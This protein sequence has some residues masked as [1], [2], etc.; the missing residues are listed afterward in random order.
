VI[1]VLTPEQ[2]R[3]VDAAAV[4]AVGEDALMHEAGRQ[5]ARALGE[6]NT[7]VRRVVAFAGPGNNGGDAF[8]ALAEL[9]RE[10]ER[11]V[12]AAPS[13]KPSAARTAAMS[14]AQES[15][16]VTRP[17]PQTED[18]AHAALAK[19]IA[20]DGLFGTGARLPLPPEYR[21]L[22][23]TL[24]ARRNL[25]LAIDVPSGID[26]L[27]GA[28]SNDAVRASLTV[29]VGAAKP[30]L[31][32]DPARECVGELWYASIGI[33]EALMSSLPRTFAALDDDAF[34][35]LLPMRPGV[36]DKRAA[37]APLVV[38][39]SPQFP[40]AAVLCARAAARAGAGYVTVAT[41]HSVANLLRTHLVEQVVVELSDDAPAESVVESLLDIA[42]HN[43]SVAIGPG[44]GLD[45]RT[46]TIVTEF[47]RR[48]AL[49]AVIDASA[50]FHLAKRLDVLKGKAAVVT[51]HAGEFARLSG[52]GTIRAGERVSRVREFVDRTGVSTLLKG[53]DTLVYDGTTMHLNATGTSALATAGSG[54]VLTGII[55]TL[56]SQGLSPVDAARAGAYWHGLAGQCAAEFRSVGVVA[57]DVIDALAEALPLLDEKPDDEL[58]RLF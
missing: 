25:V 35:K 4:A 19:A 3:A 42:Q 2:M 20:V 46:G 28:V 29:T 23:R 52:K 39:G 34:V 26:A 13:D 21:A 27:T 1:R 22:A 44:L 11:V 17:L 41:P 40:G 47:L 18:A 8:A 5:I 38:A 53:R 51:P 55:A 10:F 6:L 50:L 37:G 33:N 45:E 49:P 14:R 9:G 16:V 31:F 54:D 56:T 15:G 48:N 12:Y 7:G 24:D 32:L 36:A 30:G 58:R 43:G 57:G